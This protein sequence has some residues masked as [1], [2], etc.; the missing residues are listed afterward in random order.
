MLDWCAGHH[1]PMLPGDWQLE[2]LPY[3]F[4]CLQLPHGETSCTQLGLSP[5]S[6]CCATCSLCIGCRA[7]CRKRHPA[8]RALLLGTSSSWNRLQAFLTSNVC[9]FTCR[10]LIWGF[11]HCHCNPCPSYL[12]WQHGRAVGCH[13]W[14]DHCHWRY[15]HQTQRPLVP[16]LPTPTVLPKPPLLGRW[17]AVKSP[18]A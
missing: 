8:Q 13:H 16:Q 10:L 7:V 17:V 14:A 18:Q 1:F 4:F 15:A 9:D 2:Q 3:R 5:P 12:F 11:N 6:H